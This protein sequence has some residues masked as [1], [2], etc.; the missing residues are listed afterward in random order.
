M[1]GAT[2][3]DFGDIEQ[4]DLNLRWEEAQSHRDTYLATFDADVDTVTGDAKIFKE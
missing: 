3:P 2:D 4:R 1:G